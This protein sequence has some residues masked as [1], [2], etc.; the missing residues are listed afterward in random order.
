MSRDIF[1]MKCLGGE[2]LDQWIRDVIAM[3]DLFVIPLL[4]FLIPGA[5]DSSF[6]RNYI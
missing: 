6:V 2:Y 5:A 4:F 1:R 3:G